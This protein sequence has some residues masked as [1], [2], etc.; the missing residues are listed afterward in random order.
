MTYVTI[1]GVRLHE[2]S[3]P[4]VA[5]RGTRFA[6]CGGGSH[7]LGRLAKA[8]RVHPVAGGLEGRR[9]GPS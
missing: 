2:P 7:G 4:T 3:Q 5:E 8:P 1:N 6:L 9:C